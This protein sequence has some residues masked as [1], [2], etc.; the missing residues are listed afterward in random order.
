[1]EFEKIYDHKKCEKESQELW[2]KEKIFSFSPNK[3]LKTFSIDTPPP[4]VSGALHLGHVFSYPHQ[5]LIARYKRM[6]GY[7][8]FYPM[9]FDDNGLPTERFV[10]KKHNIKA[11]MLKRSEFISLCL[12]ETELAEKNF[13]NLWKSLG[14]SIDWSKT[15][16]TIS[17]KVRR[18]SQYSFLELYKKGLVYRQNEPALYCTTCRTS[19]AQAEIDNKEIK[20]F[21]NTIEFTNEKKQSLLV[22][23][24]RPEL[25]PACVALFCNPNDTRYTDLLNTQAIVPIF[26]TRVPI[27]IDEKV[28]PEK[29]TG[30]VMCCIFGDQTDIF[31]FKKYSLN[32]KPVI[33]QDGKWGELSG[34]LE[35]LNVHEARKKII[36]LLK[37]SGVLKEQKEITHS[38]NTH[39]RCK[40]EI[41]YLTLQQWF[42]KIL[43]YKNTFLELGGK[44]NWHP[45]FMKAR[46][47]DW[48]SNLNWDW[49]ISR[50]RFFGIPFPVWHCTK[51]H[52]IILADP[53]DLPIDPQ[54]DKCP[55][56]SCP[57]CGE[58]NFIPDT[59]IMDTWNT[60]ALTP[61]INLNWPDE[62]PDKLILPMSMRASAHDIIRTWAFY[63]IVKTYFHSNTIPW[64][65]IVISGH[66]LAGKEKI[67]KSKENSKLAP[68]TLI[69]E[70][71]ADVIRY[72]SA[73]GKLGTDT[74]FSENQLKIGQKLITKLWNAFRF[75]TQNISFDKRPE[76]TKTLDNINKWLLHNFSDTFELYCKQFDNFEYNLALETIEKFFWNIFCDNYLEIIKD[77]FFS[78]DSYTQ[79]E[80][81]TTHFAIY[82]TSFGILQLFAP[83]LP[84][85]TENLYQKLYKNIFKTK[86][87]HITTFNYILW[88]EHKHTS[89][90]K[91]ISQIISIISSVRKLKS[92][93]QVS[94]KTNVSKLTLFNLNK[95]LLDNIKTEEKIIKGI[96]KATNISYVQEDLSESSVI[97]QP[98]NSLVL[99][100]KV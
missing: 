49:C 16:S 5:D 85:I 87:I 33:N 32:F 81:K 41:E 13:E 9:G 86:S 89:S 57:S 17:D 54:E 80:L 24:T 93:T 8:V 62:S 25:L 27:L 78:P 63:T 100:V 77:R 15:Y 71:S 73:N 39:E 94:L 19:V 65:N 14:F 40:Q 26:N 30:L 31:W 58:N 47:K 50:Q 46:Y 84:H 95:D 44:I 96:T 64:E 7:N 59:D 21:F 76:H 42:V 45:D 67:S 98:D 37:E 51:C 20:S 92:E 69:Q 36:D 4:T 11:H 55:V 28:D 68:E 91:L 90:A 43:E 82:E 88:D 2:E 12:K 22:S 66:V 48:V 83:F 74:A 79:E 23:T 52:K 75:C 29:G 10:E 72:W 70:F 97:T 38:V 6:Q 18:I 60:S 1:M 35:G 56:S 61:L 99:K 34:P 53:K 3:V